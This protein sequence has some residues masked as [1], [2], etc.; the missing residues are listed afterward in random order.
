MVEMD[1]IEPTQAYLYAAVLQT[2]ELNQCSAS[3]LIW[4]IN[5]TLNNL[6]NQDWISQSDRAEIQYL[7]KAIQTLPGK[8][9]QTIYAIQT[10]PG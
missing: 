9:A 4:K 1:G 10:L 8:Y 5:Y 3:P 7:G 6:S 2:V